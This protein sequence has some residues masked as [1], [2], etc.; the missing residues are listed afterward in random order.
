MIMRSRKDRRRNCNK[1]SF[2]LRD[3]DKKMI[4]EDRRSQPDRRLC[5]IDIELQEVMLNTDRSL[6]SGFLYKR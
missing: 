6:S 1:A 3:S 4:L 2:P 5:N